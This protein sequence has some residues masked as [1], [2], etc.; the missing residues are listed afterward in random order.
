MNNKLTIVLFLGWWVSLVGGIGIYAYA[1]SDVNRKPEEVAVVSIKKEAPKVEIV[2]LEGKI[3]GNV[4]I[5]VA[6]R[7]YFRFATNVGLLSFQPKS[8]KEFNSSMELRKGDIVKFKMTF[9]NYQEYYGKYD[10][11]ICSFE[12]LEENKQ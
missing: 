9:Q 3:T 1:I 5:V 2:D 6:D 8:G 10:Q 7:I 4:Q 11:A 12:R